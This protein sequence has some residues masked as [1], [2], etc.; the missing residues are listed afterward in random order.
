MTWS[1][2]MVFARFAVARH[3]HRLR[4]LVLAQ[5]VSRGELRFACAAACTMASPSPT[6]TFTTELSPA[7][8]PRSDVSYD[9]TGKQSTPATGL[10]PARQAAVW[11]ANE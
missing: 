10:A 11:A 5:I 4:T 8:S 7:G 6:R 1:W 2:I 9:Y 3:P